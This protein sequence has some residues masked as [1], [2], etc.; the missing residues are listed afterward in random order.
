[1][2]QS[3][4]KLFALIAVLFMAT[5]ILACS[6]FDNIP[7]GSVMLGTWDVVGTDANGKEYKEDLTVTSTSTDGVHNAYKFTWQDGAE[8]YTGTGVY[9]GKA[10]GVSFAKGTNGS[11]CGAMFYNRFGDDRLEARSVVFGAENWGQE[12]ATRVSGS[13][14]EGEFTLIGK[15]PQGAV[16]SGKLT[17][18]KNGERFDLTWFVDGKEA[19][20]TGFEEGNTLAVIFGG[21]NCQ[22][23]FYKN[24][25]GFF[26][27]PKDISF[28][29]KTGDKNGFSGTETIK[30]RSSVKTGSGG[31]DNSK[32]SQ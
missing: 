26:E 27:E 1:M 6:Q 15:N 16:Y 12:T 23:A 19:K 11:G 21:D 25:L 31:N 28:V 2:K 20:G 4:N 29:G 24:N 14:F 9:L 13:G 5:Y 8:E 30:K 22:I 3:Q 18:K 10:L 32:N 7:S 17:I